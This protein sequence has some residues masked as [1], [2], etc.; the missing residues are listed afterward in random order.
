MAQPRRPAFGEG[1]HAEPQDYAPRA[2]IFDRGSAGHSNRQEDKP[3][4]HGRP[5]GVF[6]LHLCTVEARGARV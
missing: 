1:A 6:F 3:S 2:A 5:H 4:H